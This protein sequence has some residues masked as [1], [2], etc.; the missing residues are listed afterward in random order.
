MRAAVAA[1]LACPLQTLADFSIAALG[2]WGG[3]DDATPT[4]EAQ[5]MTAIGMM[6]KV[7]ELGANFTLLMGDNIYD[8]GIS[9]AASE[10]SRLRDT[11]E[12]VYPALLEGQTFYA[13][14]GNHDY[15]QGRLANISA[16]LAYS[17][18]SNTWNYPA[19]WYDI[20]RE[21]D[22]AG[23]KRSLEIL[24]LDTIVLC[25]NGDDNEGFINTQLQE[26]DHDGRLGGS[27]GASRP[28]LSERQWDWLERRMRQSAADYL[29]VT[30]HYPLW[31]AGFDA[32]T[33]CL[34]ERLQP[35]LR[36]YGGHYISGHDHMLEHVA[37]DG[38]HAFVVGAGKE[39]CYEPVNLQQ[40][41]LTALPADA[42][43]YM[44]AGKHGR[45]TSP[46]RVLGAFATLNFGADSVNVNYH[47]HDGELLY[48]A[49]PLAR[50]RLQQDSEPAALAGVLGAP[51]ACGAFV[52]L[53]FSAAT[54][55]GLAAQRRL[56]AQ[57]DWAS[58]AKSP[59]LA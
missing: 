5:R 53:V 56:S 1:L 6:R 33:D 26:I 17:Q 8:H 41:Q 40:P 23:G 36:R 12:K 24:V 15:G 42:M 29:W 55:A 51:A 47:A 57:G 19:L 7:R 20:W 50:R 43:R 16:Q 2:D 52:L 48:A 39:C 13:M 35:L 21:F 3:E 38:L 49:P 14:A 37:V 32:S 9:G 27:G 11:F 54:V 25:G 22:T 46:H 45:L 44:L 59:L 4:T 18:E 30:G 34:L 31:S 10:S 58:T 28:E